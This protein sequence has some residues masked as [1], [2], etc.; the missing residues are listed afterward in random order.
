MNVPEI[1]EA[2]R[3]SILDHNMEVLY[4]LTMQPG[5]SIELGLALF[6]GVMVLTFTISKIHI[7]SKNG[8]ASLLLTL[9]TVVV[10]A[11]CLVQVASFT[12]ICL[13]PMIGLES[14]ASVM[15]VCATGAAFLFLVVPFTRF[16]LKSGY[17][18][19]MTSWLIGMVISLAALFLLSSTYEEP[20]NG[21]TPMDTL[22]EVRGE[23]EQ[24]EESIYL[25]EV[26]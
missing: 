21:E 14:H 18:I 23:F 17:F 3:L 4:Y 16:L 22:E 26:E 2:T 25:P 8:T 15:M 19:C 1:E 5:N 9:F 7:L 6:I 11:F 10:S 24:E 12:Q 13:A 20:R